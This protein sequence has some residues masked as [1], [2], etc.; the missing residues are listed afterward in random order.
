MGLLILGVNTVY[1]AFC[2]VR[3]LAMVGKGLIVALLYDVS[4]EARQVESLKADSW[5]QRKELNCPQQDLLAC[6]LQL[7]WP[8]L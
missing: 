1:I 2:F 7:I 3:T 8:A 5:F 4:S 6:D